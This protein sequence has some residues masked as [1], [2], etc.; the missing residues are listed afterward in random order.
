MITP[1]SFRVDYPEF[2][3]QGKYPD[4]GVQLY[5]AMAG[6]LLNQNLW[7]PPALTTTNPPTTMFDIG[8]ELFI[9]HNLA[10]ELQQIKA[11]N[12]G[13]APGIMTGVVSSKSVGG[14]SISYDTA[15]GVEADASHWN[16]TTYGIRFIRLAKQFGAVPYTITGNMVPND[17]S[18]FSG[19]AWPGPP[20]F[21]LSGP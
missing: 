16:L 17:W 5:A 19:P 12:N 11:S 9:A 14:V 2:R 10:L 18:T 21:G 1:E 7:G 13:A 8:V 3:D 15:S 6:L 20:F 4:S